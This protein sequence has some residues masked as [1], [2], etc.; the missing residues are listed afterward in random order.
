MQAGNTGAPSF[1]LSMLSPLQV[2]GYWPSGEAT[3]VGDRRGDRRRA[4][5]RCSLKSRVIQQG[6]CEYWPPNNSNVWRPADGRTA[7]IFSNCAITKYL[8]RATAF[9]VNWSTH[10]PTREAGQ[11]L[12][13]SV[14]LPAPATLHE[15][16]F[17]D[18]ADGID[19]IDADDD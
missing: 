12:P 15:N 2:P 13:I 17:V 7:Q 19:G 6:F 10:R 8:S 14:T 18:V 1:C 5:G 16:P 9:T 3:V 11:L 4:G